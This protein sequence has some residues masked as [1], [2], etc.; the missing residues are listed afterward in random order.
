MA[1][2][3]VSMLYFYILKQVSIFFSC[4]YR[5]CV[6]VNTILLCCV[7]LVRVQSAIP[8]QAYILVNVQGMVLSTAEYFIFWES[9]VSV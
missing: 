3:E 8:F 9:T 5:K 2:F 7:V 1:K 4:F 6:Q